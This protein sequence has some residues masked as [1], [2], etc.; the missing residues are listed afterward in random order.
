VNESFVDVGGLRLCVSMAGP[1]RGTPVL[2]LHGYLDHAGTWTPVATALAERGHRVIVPDQR[3]F[4]RSDH[5]GA[6]GAYHFLDYVRDVDH[7]VAALRLPSPVV[8]GHSMGSTVATWWA[9]ARPTVPAAIVCVDA[10]GPPAE[11]DDQ[12]MTR[13]TA[14]LDQ[15]ARPQTHRVL[16]GLAAAAARVRRLVRVDE[17]RALTLAARITR[18]VPGGVTW[19]WDPLHRTRSP[20]GYDVDR[21]KMA[22]AAIQAP[23]TLVW[24]QGSLMASLPDLPEREALVPLHRREVWD[25][26]HNV[27][28]DEP[29]RLA[30]LIA[31]VAASALPRS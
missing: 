25:C 1:E 4:G 14:H 2:V 19:T 16:P 13:L 22:L 20:V 18:P 5:V 17:E 26:G 30:A 27:H 29:S 28:V 31:E 8:V 21:H 11:G 6:G 23:L 9:G 3:G 12:A 10:L 7:L 15:T 24:A